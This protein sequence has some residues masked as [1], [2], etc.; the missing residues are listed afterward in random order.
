MSSLRST[1][2]GYPS[3]TI[4]AVA[5]AAGMVRGT[6]VYF[7]GLA[8]DK[9][10][11]STVL[12]SSV[13]RVNGQLGY[14]M[15]TTESAGTT[16]LDSPVTIMLWG[17]VTGLLGA[18][19]VGDPVFVDDT[20]QISLTAGTYKRQI[21]EVLS[22]SGGTTYSMLFTGGQVRPLQSFED[23]ATALTFPIFNGPYD[24]KNSYVTQDVDDAVTFGRAWRIRPR[25][26]TINDGASSTL[27]K[28]YTM[29][30]VVRGTVVPSA[31]T[32]VL[33]DRPKDGF[34]IIIKDQDNS[35]AASNIQITTSGGGAGATINLA[36]PPYTL[37][38]NGQAVVLVYDEGSSNW[39]IV[40]KF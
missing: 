22:T 12:A 1:T 33:P 16:A 31:R 3:I 4:P 15:G 13:F 5:N 28:S 26:V 29:I 34:V 24:I 20:G 19:A 32:V 35:S 8:T 27:D 10:R 18:P 11:V 17:C 21:G 7:T 25:V 37:S 14:L 6:I 2:S 30:K 39:D 38:T 9:P 36:A 40:A 23:T